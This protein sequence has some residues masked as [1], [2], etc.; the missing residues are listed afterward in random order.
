LQQIVIQLLSV[1]AIWPRPPDGEVS[2]VRQSHAPRFTFLI[3]AAG[4]RRCDFI[5]PFMIKARI[6]ERGA[7]ARVQAAYTAPLITR[8]VWQGLG[9]LASVADRACV[10]RNARSKCACIY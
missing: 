7:N 2:I 1:R 9:I 6:P 5:W 4:K 10:D 3:Q 8:L